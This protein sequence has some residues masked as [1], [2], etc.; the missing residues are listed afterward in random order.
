MDPF[1]T[2]GAYDT[3]KFRSRRCRPMPCEFYRAAGAFGGQ[4]ASGS[5]RTRKPRRGPA[6]PGEDR[7][8][9]REAGLDS[10]LGAGARGMMNRRADRPMIAAVRARGHIEIPWPW[11]PC[12]LPVVGRW[13]RLRCSGI[14]AP[15]IA[16]QQ[17]QHRAKYYDACNDGCPAPR[18]KACLFAI[19][20]K[21]KRGD[22]EQNDMHA[23]SGRHFAQFVL[24]HA[25]QYASAAD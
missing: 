5:G 12:P 15:E 8:R 13:G 2:V 20:A 21:G 14:R 17:E 23:S 10:V 22:R 1:S 19:L 3:T 25:R 11:R 4:A 9:D 18:T 24:F 6:A 16:D 7:R